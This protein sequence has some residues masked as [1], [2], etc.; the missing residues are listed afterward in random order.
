MLSA[1]CNR[2]N[3]GLMWPEAANH[4]KNTL[5]ALARSG[6]LEICESSWWGYTWVHPTVNVHQ[7][8][9]K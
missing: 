8:E 3:H 4:D 5:L 1:A 2:Q 6:T 7:A 9:K